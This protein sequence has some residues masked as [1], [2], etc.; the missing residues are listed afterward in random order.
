MTKAKTL[1]QNRKKRLRSHFDFHFDSFRIN[2]MKKMG[3]KNFMDSSF[4]NHTTSV[5]TMDVKPTV[6]VDL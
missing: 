5:S 4:H 6:Y 3:I 2:P 1:N